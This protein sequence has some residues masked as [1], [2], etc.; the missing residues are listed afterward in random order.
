MAFKLV[1]IKDIARKIAVVIL[2]IVA[3]FFA[4][5]FMAALYQ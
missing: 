2:V 1:P 3:G 5:L 4:I